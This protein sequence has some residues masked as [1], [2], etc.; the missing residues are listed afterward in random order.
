MIK[1]LI[2]CFFSMLMP[3]LK[4]FADKAFR[5]L[6]LREV[7]ENEQYLLYARTGYYTGLALLKRLIILL[8]IIDNL[9]FTILGPNLQCFNYTL[10]ASD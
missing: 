6:L 3:A 1:R 7:Y 2:D 9:L 8:L 10:P 5:R 4:L